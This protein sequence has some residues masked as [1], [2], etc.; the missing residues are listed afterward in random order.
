MKPTLLIITTIYVLAGDRTL[1]YFS[2]YI[3]PYTFYVCV[4]VYLGCMYFKY[5]AVK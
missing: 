5:R 3:I 2:E 1:E 4:L